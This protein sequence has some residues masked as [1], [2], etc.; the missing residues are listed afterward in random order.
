MDELFFPKAPVSLVK[1]INNRQNSTN[2]SKMTGPCDN[3]VSISIV[4][5]TDFE[6]KRPKFDCDRGFWFCSES[7]TYRVCKDSDGTILDKQE[8]FANKS[9]TKTSKYTVDIFELDNNEII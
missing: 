5:E 7:H 8:I 2:E 3:A 9:S 1:K 4:R 6:F